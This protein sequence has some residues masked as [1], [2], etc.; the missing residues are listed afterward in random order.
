V[1]GDKTLVAPNNLVAPIMG[2]G[3]V[4]INLGSYRQ[5]IGWATGPERS[6]TLRFGV[7]NHQMVEFTLP[8]GGTVVRQGDGFW[9]SATTPTAPSGTSVTIQTPANAANLTTN[10]PFGVS[11]Q[12]VGVFE[13]S[14]VLEL[15]AAPSGNVL[16]S[17]IVTYTAPDYT[18]PGSWAATLNPGNYI[19]AAELHAVYT[20]PSGEGQVSLA[21]VPVIFR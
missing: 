2:F 6:Y 13:A 16:A 5:R 1:L 7:L 14:F 9:S 20:L 18:L 10:A 4:W 15:R 12:A 17:Q 3:K 21:T 19:G 8:N 11:G